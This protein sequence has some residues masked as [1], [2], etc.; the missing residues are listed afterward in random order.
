MASTTVVDDIPT[1]ESPLGRMAA[2]T[3]NDS[4]NLTNETRALYVGTAG[5]VKITTVGGD[6]VTLPNLAAGVWHPIR[7]ARVWSTGTT[8]SDVIAGW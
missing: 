6:A 4:T 2:V 3:P 1:L 5:N 8:A 7:A